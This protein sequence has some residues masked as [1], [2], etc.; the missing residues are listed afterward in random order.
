[1]TNE[2]PKLIL[3]DTLYETTFNK[4]FLSRKPYQKDDPHKISAFI[5]GI[6]KKIFIYEGKR[7]KKGESL[8]LLEAMKMENTVCAPAD[9]VVKKIHIKEGDIVVKNQLI[10]EIEFI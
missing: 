1:M 7:A 6:I 9:V 3:D 8:L 10:L 5:P 4:K 2:T